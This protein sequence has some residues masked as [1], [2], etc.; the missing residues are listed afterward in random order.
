[1][2]GIQLIKYECEMKS[3]IFSHNFFKCVL[4]SVKSK[5]F[6]YILVVLFLGHAEYTFAKGDADTNNKN[7]YLLSRSMKIGN[8]PVKDAIFSPDDQ[9]A[10]V[11]SGSSA[12]EIYR[13]QRI[14]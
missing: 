1:M 10:V 9:H 5:I 2:Y 11:L 4:L 8:N 3:K 6:K 14:N 12:L 13:N 7:V